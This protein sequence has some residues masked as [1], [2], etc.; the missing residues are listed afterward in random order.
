MKILQICQY[1]YPYFGGQEMYVLQLSKKLKENG[2]DVTI[3]TSNH[4]NVSDHENI[5]GINVVRFKM[6][7]NPLNNPICLGFFNIRNNLKD[8][9]II[10]VHNEHGFV[11]LVSCLLNLYYKKP[12]I[13]TCHGQLIFGNWIKDTFEKIYSMTIGKMLFNIVDTVVA[14][15]EGDKE[16]ICSLGID[17]NKITVLSNAINAERMDNLYE[18]EIESIKINQNKYKD[19][20]IIL[21]VG[22]II[23]RKGI[24][25]LLKAFSEVR[26]VNN[27]VS[28]FIAGDGNYKKDAESLAKKLNIDEYVSFFGRVSEEQFKDLD[29]GSCLFQDA[30]D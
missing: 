17:P 25:Y 18:K 30:I 23:K 14:N 12:I 27:N 6:L 7:F 26:K 20:N 16:Y 10:N 24:D 3:Y 11:T 1:F 22:S 4:A 9:D 5:D 21:F 2:N 28:L 29:W 8:F 19:N 15:S 13:L